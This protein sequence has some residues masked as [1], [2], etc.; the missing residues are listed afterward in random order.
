[1]GKQ[2]LSWGKSA[3]TLVTPELTQKR[4]KNK[5]VGGCGA[6]SKSNAKDETNLCQGGPVGPEKIPG[7]KR[8]KTKQ[9]T[10]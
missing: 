1:M 2:T 8:K 7:E 3:R 9:T 10:G 4:K 5:V 6:D